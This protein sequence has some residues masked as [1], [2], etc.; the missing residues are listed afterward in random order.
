MDLFMYCVCCGFTVKSLSTFVSC[1]VCYRICV[2]L[3][4][5]FHIFFTVFTSYEEDDEDRNK[6]HL[7]I[8]LMILVCNYRVD[9]VSPSSPSSLF[10]SKL[11]VIFC[12]NL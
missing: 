11:F 6:Q 1:L 7:G 3:G 10:S 8:Q 2:K 4:S 12:T 5:A 9:L